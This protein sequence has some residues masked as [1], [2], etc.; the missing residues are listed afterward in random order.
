VIDQVEAV[1]VMLEKY[2][3]CQGLFHSFDWSRW[4][5]GYRESVSP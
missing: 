1:A 3:I 5:T 4:M 2:E